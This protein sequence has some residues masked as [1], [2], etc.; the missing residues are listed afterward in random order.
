[1]SALARRGLTVLVCLL[2]VL[3]D[4]SARP[5]TSAHDPGPADVGLAAAG[6]PPL[7]GPFPLWASKYSAELA[8]SVCIVTRA[9]GGLDSEA[10]L[11]AHMMSVFVPN[12]P[13]LTMVLVEGGRGE[14]TRRLAAVADKFNA[15]LGRRGVLVSRWDG[16]RA[17][18]RFPALSQD[19]LGYLALD[20][21][22]D[23]VVA[24]RR[25]DGDG[26]AAARA[27]APCDFVILSD[28]ANLYAT[29]FLPLLMRRLNEGA[30]MVGVHWV[31]RH[32]WPDEALNARSARQIKEAGACGP[33]RS[34]RNVEIWAA[35]D[36]RVGCIDL[37]AVMLRTSVLAST[38]ARLVLES[39]PDDRATGASVDFGT[40]DG[41]L[42]SRLH[43]QLGGR[44]AIIRRALMFQQ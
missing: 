22:L 30:D 16:A 32:H 39:L 11:L 1:M 6:G 31:S 3:A 7:L 44:S 21:A 23:D 19:D 38:K 13:R 25:L 29:H 10:R 43:K 12:H 36:F 8:Q 9:H 33:L 17:R 14:H 24:G 35:E 5:P 34:G 42:Y 15:H 20:L 4:A 2:I 40:V 37:G 28:S 18:A 41:H 26:G 27:D